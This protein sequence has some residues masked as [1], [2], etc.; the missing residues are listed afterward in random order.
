MQQFVK[1]IK[2]GEIIKTKI[3]FLPWVIQVTGV[4]LNYWI[5]AHNAFVFKVVL[6]SSAMAL[7]KASS[8]ASAYNFSD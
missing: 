2:L 6:I 3:Y 8:R 4:N 7:L 1:P 5:I